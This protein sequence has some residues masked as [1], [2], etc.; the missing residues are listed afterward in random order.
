M[1][2]R[3]LGHV[4][5]TEV[6]QIVGSSHVILKIRFSVGAIFEYLATIFTAEVLLSLRLVTV[7]VVVLED[8]TCYESLITVFAAEFK[9]LTFNLRLESF[10]LLRSFVDIFLV[11]LE[12]GAV[13][14]LNV[15]QPA[16]CLPPNVSLSSVE[17]QCGRADKLEVTKLTGISQHLLFN[18]TLPLLQQGPFLLVVFLHMSVQVERLLERLIAKLTLD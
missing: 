3:V 1:G 18:A 16:V 5:D 17:P 6:L 2:F 10:Q 12:L 4:I 7:G 13:F 15:A 11:S 9:V 8:I 14:K